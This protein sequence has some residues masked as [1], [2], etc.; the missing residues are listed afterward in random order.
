MPRPPRHREPQGFWKEVPYRTLSSMHR[1]V[2]PPEMIEQ[3]GV[4][5]GD[6]LL[7]EKGNDHS[8]IVT[9]KPRG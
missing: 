3:L 5:E 7:F 9:K 8:V 6:I 1:V 4:G 2:I